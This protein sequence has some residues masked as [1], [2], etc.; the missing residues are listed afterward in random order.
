LLL[1]PFG[2]LYGDVQRTL[3]LATGFL[4]LLTPV[5]YPTPHSGLAAKILALN[6]LTP[7]VTTTREWLTSGV[8]SQLAGFVAVTAS[9]F[10]VLIAAWIV[11]RVAMPHVIARLGS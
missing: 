7:L 11:Y 3:P 2:L 1:T 6:P 5:I 9:A 10:I 4:M 8:T